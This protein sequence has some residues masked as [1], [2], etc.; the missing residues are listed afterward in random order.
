M[1]GDLERGNPLSAPLK[2]LLMRFKDAWLCALRSPHRI[3][4]A[5]VLFVQKKSF[6]R[7]A[8]DQGWSL[9]ALLVIISVGFGMTIRGRL[10]GL[11]LVAALCA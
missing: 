1:A 6:H 5:R 8:N 11:W 3:D 4:S 9:S 2:Y 10:S 7:C